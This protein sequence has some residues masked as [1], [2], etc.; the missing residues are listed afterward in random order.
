MQQQ[1]LQGAD[2]RAHDRIS[3]DHPAMLTIRGQRTRACRLR[4]FCLGGL[5]IEVPRAPAGAPGTAAPPLAVRGDPAVVRFVVGPASG[6]QEFEMRLHVVRVLEGGVGAAFVDPSP[7]AVRALG[8]LAG[9][10]PARPKASTTS[11]VASARAALRDGIAAHLEP[12]LGLM[13]RNIGAALVAAGRDAYGRREE[14]HYFDAMPILEAAQTAIARDVIG[15]VLERVSE[16]GRGNVEPRAHPG[17][18]MSDSEIS[19]ELRLVDLDEFE[20]FLLVAG[21]ASAVEQ[22]FAAPLEELGARLGRALG[23]TLLRDDN[24]I[25]PAAVCHAY[26]NALRGLALHEN[27]RRVL[28][29]EFE[30]QVAPELGDLYLSLNRTL[31]AAG[32]GRAELKKKR[33]TRTRPPADARP[34]DGD[35][36]TR[37]ADSKS[38]A[39]VARPGA[40][41]DTASTP[42]DPLESDT[43]AEVTMPSA[44]ETTQAL[45]ALLRTAAPDA[46][47]DDGVRDDLLDAL[48]ELQRSD[49]GATAAGI[50]EDIVGRLNATL[51]AQSDAAARRLTASESEPIEL[52]QRLFQAMRDDATLGTGTVARLARL[53]AVVHRANLLEA[54]FLDAA[55]H[56]A[57]RLLDALGELDS[58][59]DD[60]DPSL[61]ETREQIDTVV[62]FAVAAYNRDP[63]PV[64]LAASN[65]ETL[66][67]EAAEQFRCNLAETL[68]EHETQQALL[69]ARRGNTGGP[70]PREASRA[71]ELRVWFNRIWRLRVGDSL[72]VTDAGPAP[73]TH[74][75][76][77]IGEGHEVLL[78]VDARG[79]KAELANLQ[80]LALRLRRGTVTP[81]PRERLPLVARAL[82]GVLAGIRADIEQRATHDAGSG[83]ANARQFAGRVAAA[84]TRAV[85]DH[86]QHAL[87]HVS[88]DTS[89]GDRGARPPVATEVLRATLGAAL[90]IGCLGDGE[91]GVLIESCNT[92]TVARTA[93]KLRLALADACAGAAGV[94]M[95]VINRRTADAA[96][97]LDLARAAAAKARVA[98]GR[99]VH[100]ARV[101]EIG[102]RG[103]GPL[104]EWVP[105][106]NR[107]LREGQTAFRWQRI[108]PLRTDATREAPCYELLL[109][110]RDD[111]GNPVAPDHLLQA[112]TYYQHIVELDRCLIHSALAWMAA[113]PTRLASVGACSINLADQTLADDRLLEFLL[114]ELR[115]SGVPPAKICFEVSQAAVLDNLAAAE[116]LMFTLR[117][118]GC[119]FTLVDNGGGASVCQHLQS[120]PVEFVK[121]G[122]LFVRDAARCDE[123]L[124]VVQAIQQLA[125]F[126]GKRTIA[127]RVEDEA[128]LQVLRAAG[129][130]YAQGF[131][132]DRPHA[133]PGETTAHD[134]G[135]VLPPQAPRRNEPTTTAGAAAQTWGL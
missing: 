34:D 41:P 131:A 23:T 92:D 43:Q 132:V 72:R 14:S 66:A 113:N 76:A 56:P 117:E 19:A 33:R 107:T 51:A 110:V 7:A 45:L 6:G 77:W 122:G 90:D 112:A 125:R 61:A 124:A 29:A 88:L 123:D 24:P 53:Q 47:V 44:T 103:T 49:F 27:A 26:R 109:E 63:A 128:T 84:L 2:R 115:E 99:R 21:M 13:L 40:A 83:L 32:I 68:A 129:V 62:D 105:V 95:T 36:S 91:F 22:R 64:A 38:D 79:R 67:N 87:L 106:L 74:T 135:S 10:R 127:E 85:H 70:R 42:G 108:A 73:R 104:M 96:S 57:R 130:D 16:F 116:D 39:T 101:D 59:L 11:R 102:A 4:D 50:G 118:Y 78:L 93:E 46:G 75:V 8:R 133:P 20:D 48:R 31:E 17:E 69:S 114:G 86:L 58:A 120:L 3:I 52:V 9:E 55:R 81:L 134:A 60:D 89:S 54:G 37:A 126:F 1:Q 121:I 94:G 18:R 25:C 30:R 71:R 35:T 98:G 100:I 12:R 97:A 28:Y 15:A 82:R 5:H 111:D 119:R 65:L 80:E